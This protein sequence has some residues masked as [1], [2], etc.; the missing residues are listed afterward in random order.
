MLESLP[1][2]ILA[3]NSPRRRQLLSLEG[4]AYQVIPARVD[5]NPQPEESPQEVVLRL[6]REKALDVG[7]IAPGGSIIIAADTTVVACGQILGKP[8]SPANAASIL[9][10]LRGGNHQVITGLA[11]WEM[12]GNT[13][14]ADHCVTSVN[15]REYSEVEI[16]AYI[17]TGDPLDKA[18]AYAIQHRVFDPV[19]RIEGCYANV[20]GLPLCLLTALLSSCGMPPVRHI[21]ASCQPERGGPC[22]VASMILPDT[23]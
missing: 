12:A 20:V 21:T 6:A 14:L 19:E 3:S 7:K 15:M 13:F 22:R 5:E 1:M 16:Q 8:T 17:A 2:L 4:W 11:V 9:R 18:G 23:P 10:E